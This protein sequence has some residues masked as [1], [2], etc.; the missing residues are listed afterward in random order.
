[1]IV[2][3]KFLAPELWGAPSFLLARTVARADALAPPCSQ[4]PSSPCARLARSHSLHPRNTSLTLSLALLQL[5]GQSVGCVINVQV[6]TFLC[7]SRAF[8]GAG[9]DARP[10]SSPIRPLSLSS[11]PATGQ[12]AR[13]RRARQVAGRK[14][15]GRGAREEGA[16]RARQQACAGVSALCS[17]EDGARRRASAGA[18]GA[19]RRRRIGDPRTRR[20]RLPRLNRPRPASPFF[21][22]SLLPIGTFFCATLRRASP[23]VCT[24]EASRCER[25]EAV[26]SRAAAWLASAGRAAS[27]PH[28]RP[29]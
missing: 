1:M 27:A 14:G 29:G 21:P 11:H 18:A 28:G 20:L 26:A 2:A 22:F 4:F 9:A 10:S 23:S 5:V 8:R 17:C 25:G 16:G 12:E 19:V 24:R 7:R 13:H 6:R 15:R 3:Q